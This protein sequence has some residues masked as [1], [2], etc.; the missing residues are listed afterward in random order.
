MSIKVIASKAVT[1][2][3]THFEFRRQ[4][5]DDGSYGM[6]NDTL[7]DCT[8]HRQACDCLVDNQLE[9]WPVSLLSKIKRK[10]WIT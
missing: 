3:N 2:Q 1:M 9:D 6:L 5:L 4:W 10:M 8:V 7:Q